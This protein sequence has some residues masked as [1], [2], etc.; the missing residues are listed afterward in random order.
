[1]NI[2]IEFDMKNITVTEFG[3]GRDED[4]KQSYYYV[5]VDGDVQD[6]LSEM[7]E[8]TIKAMQELAPSLKRFEPS[9]KY[10]GLEYVYIPIDDA[11]ANSIM[12]LHQAE[13][14][15]TK[16]GAMADTASIFCYFVRFSDS[17][18]KRLTAIRRATQFKGIL[19]SR[20]HLIRLIDDSLQII[21]DD[22][23]KLDVDFDFLVDNSNIH[24]LRPSSFEFAGRITGAVLEAVPQNIKKLE[25]ELSFVEFSNIS[26]YASEHPRAAHYLAAIQTQKEAENI[27]RRSLIQLCNRTG[28]KVDTSGVQIV[29]DNEHIMGFL[30][31]LD[32]RRYEIDLVT[33]E[34]ERYRAMS[35]ERL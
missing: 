33:N 14:L 16:E 35:R 23:F 12:Q 9:E 13:N 1:M 15:V 2:E 18:G 31:V 20:R 24:I 6:T 28:V 21:K 34:P 25:L 32:R 8:T 4:D 3:I 7:T 30:E 29:V 17:Q 19:K 10:A 11:L 5:P 26:D 22:V 27:N